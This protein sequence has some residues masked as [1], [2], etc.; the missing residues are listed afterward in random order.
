MAKSQI[1]SGREPKKPKK[2]KPKSLPLP[3]SKPT[4]VVAAAL[5]H[6]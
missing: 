5:E 1:R 6:K 3:R 2:V 4:S